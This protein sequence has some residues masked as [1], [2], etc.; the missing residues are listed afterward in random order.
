MPLADPN[1]RARSGLL[2][3]SY[4]D[5]RTAE[6]P[7]H[8]QSVADVGRKF[9]AGQPIPPYQEIAPSIL[10]H[11]IMID[12]PDVPRISDPRQL[13]GA[14]RTAEWDALCVQLEWWPKL[15]PEARLRIAQVL[16]KLGFWRTIAVQCA[17][18]NS[19]VGP[20]PV[21]LQLRRIRHVAETKL[22]GRDNVIFAPESHPDL[23]RLATGEENEVSA[24]IPAALNLL[25]H[26]A[27]SPERPE[28]QIQRWSTLARSLVESAPSSSLSPIL[29]S[30]YWRGL[31]FISFR[32]G[33]HAETAA[34]LDEAEWAADRA[35]EEADPDRRLLAC[36]N[37]YLV[38]LTR[39]RAAA[40][41]GMFDAAE[42]FHRSLVRQD[43]LSAQAHVLLG[44]FLM[45][46]ERFHE[47]VPAFATAA[48]L[49]A[50]Y[51]GYARN[52]AIRCAALLKTHRKPAAS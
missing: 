5:L 10:R 25:M 16:L 7:L 46:R 12:D 21:A 17:E 8:A 35:V 29:L 51:S 4:F 19:Q 32:G 39:A 40:A 43:P 14:R 48:R 31:S 9:L 28:E 1:A 33:A 36:E 22:A 42:R 6:G 20:P 47:A 52:Q 37:R 3:A 27:R 2:L 34:M 38:V 23:V 15:A 45:V 18:P 41:A 24:R 44:E 13:A 30:A 50:P 26:H 11:M 49:G